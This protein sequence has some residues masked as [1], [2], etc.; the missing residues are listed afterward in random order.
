MLADDDDA[1]ARLMIA[2]TA[3]LRRSRNRWLQALAERLDPPGSAIAASS[4]APSG[5]LRSAPKKAD[6][7]DPV[8]R[9]RAHRKRPCR[10]ATEQRDELAAFHSIT[11]S[12][13]P[14]TARGKMSPNVLAV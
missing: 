10:R 14:R 4:V 6:A 12:A 13:R 9:L 3:I 2:A 7:R 11:S 8:G 1:L 5:T